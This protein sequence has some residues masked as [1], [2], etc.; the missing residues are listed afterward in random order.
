MADGNL[1]GISNGDANHN[2]CGSDAAPINPF[3]LLVN[4]LTDSGVGSGLTGDLRY[5]LNQADVAAAQG[6]AP[7]IV[8]A[9]TLDGQTITLT[10][11]ELELTSASGLI[12][13]DGGGAVTIWRWQLACFP[14][15]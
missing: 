12:T 14:G 13:I 7:T 1:S 6:I 9:S 10:Q 11:G 2:L 3:R 4:A 15:R 5:C 8:F